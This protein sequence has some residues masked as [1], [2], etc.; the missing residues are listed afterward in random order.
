M[1]LFPL[2]RVGSLGQGDESTPA[3]IFKK[4]SS[5]LTKCASSFEKPA[6]TL[7]TSL[8]DLLLIR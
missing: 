8:S 7:Q 1:K 4:Y 3:G 6:I 5:V 2:A